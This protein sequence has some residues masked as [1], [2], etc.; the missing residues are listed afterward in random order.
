MK[1]KNNKLNIKV[2]IVIIVLI[3]ISGLVYFVVS[4]TSTNKDQVKPQ[5]LLSLNTNQ[6]QYTPGEEVYIQIVS[7]DSL[8]N[9]LC[10]SNLE[11][12]IYQNGEFINSPQIDVSPSCDPTNSASLNPDYSASF[13]PTSEGV[14][15]IKIIDL[16]NS[17]A[18]EIQITVSE[19]VQDFSINRW[20]ATRL[21][22]TNTDR[23][24]MKL[25]I[26]SNKDFIGQVIEQIP[27]EFE[28]IWQGPARVE[29]TDDGQ[30]ISW[31][32]EI[33]AGETK[34][35]TYE[36]TTPSVLVKN[37]SLGPAKLVSSNKKVFFEENRPWQIIVSENQL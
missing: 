17:D 30:I 27:S 31:E 20:G 10:D 8:G 34:E 12:S 3:V 23:F 33:E 19:N 11:L 6:A 36:Y 26:T 37:Y 14:Y 5:G 7:T 4:K 32:T 21:N 15:Q 13:T 29:K 25:T 24:P 22:P 28:V 18:N 2:F 35:F 1:N 16:D 9:T